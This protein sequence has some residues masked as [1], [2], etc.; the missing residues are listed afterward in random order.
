MNDDARKEL[1]IFLGELWEAPH[2]GWLYGDAEE[3]DNNRT[4]TTF[5]DMGLLARK[6]AEKGNQAVWD[7]EDY[8]EGEWV[9][10]KDGGSLFV[11]LIT[12]PARFAKLVYD[13]GVWRD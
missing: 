6:M 9:E 1:T 11:W 2:I 7:F 12:D 3:I 10:N 5:E 13:S 8:A 4:F